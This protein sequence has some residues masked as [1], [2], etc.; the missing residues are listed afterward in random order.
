MSKYLPYPRCMIRAM[1]K[2]QRWSGCLLQKHQEVKHHGLGYEGIRRE[3]AYLQLRSNNRR[4]RMEPPAAL[5]AERTMHN[6]AVHGTLVDATDRSSR[7]TPSGN[8]C[9]DAQMA[10]RVCIVLGLL[11]PSRRRSTPVCISN[12][13]HMPGLLYYCMRQDHDMARAGCSSFPARGLQ[14]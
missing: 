8:T 13:I 1:N 10:L 6:A 12:H 9:L 4:V 3:I 2:E 5:S 11:Q 7:L 14:S